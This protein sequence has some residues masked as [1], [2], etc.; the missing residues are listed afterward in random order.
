[1]LYMVIETFKENRVADVYNRAKQC[2][3]ITM[4]LID[5]NNAVK[6]GLKKYDYK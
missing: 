2:G 6:G 5:G 1:M 4:Q 3:R